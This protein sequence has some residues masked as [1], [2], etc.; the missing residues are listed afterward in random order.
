[1]TQYREEGDEYD[2]TVRFDEKYRQS[3]EDVETF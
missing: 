1:M 2:I 3:L